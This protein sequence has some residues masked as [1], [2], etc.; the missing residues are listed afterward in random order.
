MKLFGYFDTVPM[1]SH[2]QKATSFSSLADAKK[3]FSCF[4]D[5]CQRFGDSK[6]VAYLF[7]GTPDGDEEV[8]GYPDSYEYI[9][10]SGLRGGINVIR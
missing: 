3:Q 9:F 10:E 2:P 4:V 7:S 5:D 8:Y 1:S 6:A